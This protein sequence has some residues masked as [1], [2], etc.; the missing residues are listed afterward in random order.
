[1][2]VIT[3]VWRT[4]SV[5]LGATRVVNY[6][7]CSTV[8]ITYR[9]VKTVQNLQGPI[10]RYLLGITVS[11]ASSCNFYINDLHQTE[12]SHFY[13]VTLLT[14]RW[15]IYQIE[16][17]HSQR[18]WQLKKKSGMVVAT[19]MER[20]VRSAKV[21]LFTGALLFYNFV[22][23]RNYTPKNLTYSYVFHR[24]IILVCSIIMFSS[25]LSSLFYS[26][27]WCYTCFQLF[28]QN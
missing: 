17:H 4:T 2:T 14:H 8:G 26:E 15:T 19:S 9:S 28:Q 1:M 21:R 3:L 12:C 6:H 20:K 16:F 5:W 11:H 27:C 7:L 24:S 10:W 23:L 25:D 18:E 13:C 22:F